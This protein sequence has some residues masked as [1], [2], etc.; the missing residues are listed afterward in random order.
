[1]LGV[2]VPIG[3]RTIEIFPPTET[4]V[5]TFEH[6]TA[7]ESLGRP[8]E[9]DVDILSLSG[10]IPISPVLGK[11]FSVAMSQGKPPPRWFNGIVTRFGQ[12][13]WTGEAFRY[14]AR[15]RPTLWLMTLT[16]NCRIFQNMTVP[17]VVMEL[18]NAHGVTVKRHLGFDKYPKWEYL[19]QY[20]ETDFNFV[21]RMM[22][23]EG[24]FYYFVHEKGKHTMFL[25]DALTVPDKIKG[26]DEVP[27]AATG[28]R[29]TGVT[30]QHET[31]DS[32]GAA[33]QVEPGAYT[34]KEFD[35]EDPRNELKS[36]A[37]APQPP[38][39]A[40]TELFEYPGHY[41]KTPDRDEYVK[42]RLDEQQLEYQQIQGTGNA[43]GIAAGFVFKLADHPAH[44][45]NGEYLI[46]AA[47]YN[48][49]ATQHGSGVGDAGPDYRCSFY[50][51]DSKRHYR[52]PVTTPKPLVPGPQTAT[53]VG[54]K[55]EEI[56][57]DK[58]GRV[59]V[60]F[61]W[62]RKGTRD[63]KSS[64]F[65][66]VSQVWAGSGW[67]AMHIPRIGQEVI[68]DFLEGDPDRP[69]IT[70]RVYNGANMPPYGLGASASKS[71]IRSHSTKG[72]GP[73]N[74]NELC[75][76]DKIGNEEVYLQAEKDLEILVKNDEH[77]E[78]KHDR[79]KDVGNDETT[80]VGGN[81]TETV[82]KDETIT[83]SGNRTESVTKNETITID[84]ARTET[85][86]KDETITIDGGRTETVAKNETVTISGKQTLSVSKDQTIDVGGP[87]S[88]TVAKDE[89][90]T[91]SGKDSINVSKDMS[92][93]VGK[94]F[95]LNAGDEITFKTGDSSI[96]LKSGGDITIKGKS[97]VINGSGDVAVKAGGNV[98]IKGT[99]IGQN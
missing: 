64:C 18:L 30:E 91:I 60:Q 61:H 38:S 8:F 31:I 93:D 55:G 85:V 25:V 42:R 45:Q 78:V 44:T 5:V 24:I 51:I 96:T 26:Y 59:K 66:R 95:L 19:V 88:L 89:T 9:F 71:T 14:R 79:K 74:Y 35:F 47:S 53:I 17:D 57:T 99:K 69:I 77:R 73:N 7:S 15:L 37:A 4:G 70:G 94:K 50:G 98:T 23:L 82:T 86:S 29:A 39:T 32:W 34:A 67:G 97:I 1:M 48:M 81:R 92:I 65:V 87:R 28:D 10:D 11:P 63:E 80:T 13:G 40:E 46:T 54:P 6:M 3:N 90:I 56:W 58:Y 33:L 49:T 68:V 62:D 76:E 84:G 75:F 72:G 43:R 36:T 2:P 21:S 52:P 41:I 16:S 20:N 83:I 12:V 22:E 27:F